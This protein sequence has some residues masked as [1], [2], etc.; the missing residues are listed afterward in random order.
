MVTGSIRTVGRWAACLAGA[1]T[2]VTGAQAD[3]VVGK[4]LSPVEDNW[5][6]IPIHAALTPDGR[7]LTYGTDGSG[8]QTAYFIYD[9]WDPVEGLSG[10][11]ITLDNMTL[12]DVF[13]SSQVVLPQSGSILIAGGDNWTGSNTT[14]TGNNNSNI[15]SSTVSVRSRHPRLVADRRG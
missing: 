11:H 12:T 5:P 8:R 9:V 13:C 3:N 6:L 10:G 15:F 14:N 7:V 4:W 2:L 1:L